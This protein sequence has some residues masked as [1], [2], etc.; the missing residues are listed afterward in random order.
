VTRNPTG[1]AGQLRAMSE[2]SGYTIEK[3]DP[4]P[5]GWSVFG[6]DNHRIGSVVDLLVDIQA[7]KVRQLLVATSN[8]EGRDS[9]AD[10]SLVAIDID[11]VD[12]RTDPREVFASGLAGATFRG[13]LC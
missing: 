9:E 4:D 11:D 13:R 7:M 10:E 1:Q 3:G 6:F 12:V 5:R 8:D 2:L